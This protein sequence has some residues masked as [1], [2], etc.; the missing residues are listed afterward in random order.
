MNKHYKICLYYRPQGQISRHFCWT[1]LVRNSRLDDVNVVVV[2]VVD[3]VVVVV[4]VVVRTQK[5]F[6]LETIFL[7]LARFSRS[8]GSIGI[9]RDTCLFATTIGLSSSSHFSKLPLLPRL[10]L[11]SFPYQLYPTTLDRTGL[12]GWRVKLSTG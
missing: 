8:C 7:L 9:R 12:S 11:P 5:Q 10:T 1:S 6:H 3:V 4:V 2:V